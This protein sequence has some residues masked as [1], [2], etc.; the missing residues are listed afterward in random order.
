MLEAARKHPVII[1]G[2]DHLTELIVTDIHESNQHI[3]PSLLG[4]LSIRFHIIGA[5]RIVKKVT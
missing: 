1:H 5:K 2:R 3:S 4:L